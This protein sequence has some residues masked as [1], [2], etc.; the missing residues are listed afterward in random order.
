VKTAMILCTA[1]LTVGLLSSL[2]AAQANPQYGP[3]AHPVGTVQTYSYNITDS[4]QPQYPGTP[5]YQAPAAPS[6]SALRG[7]PA[8]RQ[9]PLPPR[10]ANQQPLPQAQPAVQRSAAKPVT[11]K[12]RV[13]SAANRPNLAAAPPQR[14]MPQT[15]AAA[16]Y[17]YPQNYA[18]QQR[19]YQQ[20]T[21]YPRTQA[22]YYAN[23]YQSQYA[24]APNYYQGYSYNGGLSGQACAPGRA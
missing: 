15:R 10:V 19:S 14:P 5:Q 13:Q 9:Q 21:Y 11:K 2:A 20:Q 3:R 4:R 16:A 1:G 18:P 6:G 22:S 8:M 7:Q 23:P 12:K 17:Q 24:A